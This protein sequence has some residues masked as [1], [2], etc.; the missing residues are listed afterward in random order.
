MTSSLAFEVN[1]PRERE[2]GHTPRCWLVQAPS[3]QVSV[4]CVHAAHHTHA[5]LMLYRASATAPIQY[6]LFP[7]MWF[8]LVIKLGQ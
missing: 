2:R 8:V 4:R 5:P 6:P 1:T 7:I 3:N